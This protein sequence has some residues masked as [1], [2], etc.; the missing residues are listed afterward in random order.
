MNDSDAEQTTQSS[1]LNHIKALVH[2]W[3]MVTY[4]NMTQVL[5]LS[6]PLLTWDP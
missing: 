6:K 4:E 3:P 1:P 2:I 5:G